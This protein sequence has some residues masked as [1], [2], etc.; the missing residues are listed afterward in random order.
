MKTQYMWFSAKNGIVSY[1][2]DVFDSLGSIVRIYGS[3]PVFDQTVEAV[4][5]K[6]ARRFCVNSYEITLVK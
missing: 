4:A 1:H 6:L 2:G 5:A 3:E